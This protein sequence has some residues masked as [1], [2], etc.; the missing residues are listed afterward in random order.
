MIKRQDLEKRKLAAKEKGGKI[1]GKQPGEA[2]M[3]RYSL[4]DEDFLK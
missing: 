2:K 1:G 4:L 3:S